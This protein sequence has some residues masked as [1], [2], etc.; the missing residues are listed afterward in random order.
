MDPISLNFENY[1][2]KMFFEMLLE[3]KQIKEWD[4]Y[5]QLRDKILKIDSKK[6]YCALLYYPILCK[7]LIA[8][9]DDSDLLEQN[10]YVF[11]FVSK[12]ELFKIKE[13]YKRTMLPIYY[14]LHP[15]IEN[16]EICA[17]G[18]YFK[19]SATYFEEKDH[20]IHISFNS[21]IQNVMY[22]DKGHIILTSDET[23]YWSKKCKL[24]PFFFEKHNPI[25]KLYS[26]IWFTSLEE[27][28][29]NS[30]IAAIKNKKVE[31]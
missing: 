17:I 28:L 2:T 1:R 26:Y 16:L 6:N 24:F 9:L 14:I 20:G 3:N 21:L 12:D 30:A 10:D 11:V 25:E 29:Y 7:E 5:N 22:N 8:T 15:G 27:N 4:K 31:Q 19:F 13:K 18:I 23:I